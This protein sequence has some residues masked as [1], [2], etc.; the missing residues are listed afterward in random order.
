MTRSGRVQARQPRR[1]SLGQ[2]LDVPVDRALAGLEG[3]GE[4]FGALHPLPLQL[5][6]DSEQA[7]RAVHPLCLLP[8]GAFFN[9]TGENRYRR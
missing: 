6:H 4:V 1:P 7:I 5:Q 9:C 2:R 8:A 3:G